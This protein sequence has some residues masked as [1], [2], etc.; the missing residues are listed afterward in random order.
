MSTLREAANE[1]LSHKSIAVAGS[2]AKETQQQTSY[3]KN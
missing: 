1:F 2:R 3:I